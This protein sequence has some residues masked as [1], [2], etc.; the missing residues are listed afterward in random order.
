MLTL[1]AS[2][3]VTVS[4]GSGDVHV[5]ALGGALTVTSGAGDVRTSALASGR[6]GAG[7]VEVVLLAGDAVYRVDADS[8]AGS[9]TVDV[10]TAPDAAHTVRARSDA[11]DVRV[12]YAG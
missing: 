2:V 9:R 4:T 5:G 10:R 11:G 7:D 6:V 8:G 1:P 12:R 3:P